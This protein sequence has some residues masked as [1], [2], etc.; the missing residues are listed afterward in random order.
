MPPTW[1]R[2]G[3]RS[4]RSAWDRRLSS[5]TRILPPSPI[6]F[7]RLPPDPVC[8]AQSLS[9]YARCVPDGR[10]EAKQYLIGV[11]KMDGRYVKLTAATSAANNCS[12]GLRAD[13]DRLGAGVRA[14]D[15]VADDGQYREQDHAGDVHQPGVGDVARP[16]GFRA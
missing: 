6:P 15:R 4:A 7:Y 16:F 14:I 9:A 3:D 1:K 10:H 12:G 8:G 5:L 11:I 13:D 2:S